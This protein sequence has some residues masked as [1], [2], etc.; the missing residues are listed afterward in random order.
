MIRGCQRQMIVLETKE[1][2]LFE[3]AYFV[4]RRTRYT[5]KDDEMVCEA[6]R[7]IGEGGLYVSR[8]Q[9]RRGVLTF[10]I[11]A[12]VGALFAALVLGLFGVLLHF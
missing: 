1:S 5:A 8:R 10:G 6:E 7:L 12:G 11:G 2:D 9:R 4:L 3:Q